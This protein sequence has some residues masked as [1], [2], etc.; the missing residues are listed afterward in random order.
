MPYFSEDMVHC[1]LEVRDQGIGMTPQQLENLFVPF[2]RSLRTEDQLRNPSGN[3]LGLSI[4]K[5]IIDSLGGEITAQS[6]R[7]QGSIF[8]VKLDV[9]QVSRPIEEGEKNTIDEVNEQR[10]DSNGGRPLELRLDSP[11]D[12]SSQ[13]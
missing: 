13:T 9:A 8:N 7:G 11:F 4:C 6:R 10:R 3:G 12:E 5:R 2:S 1:K